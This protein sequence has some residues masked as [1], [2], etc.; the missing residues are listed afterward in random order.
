MS[1]SRLN[2]ARIAATAI[3]IADESGIGTVS[4]RGI[5]SELGVHVTSLY[6]HVPT[7]D[8]V[9]NEMVRKAYLGEQ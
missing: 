2:R 9:L 7:T 3:G 5:S 6:N 8:A 1:R 4:L